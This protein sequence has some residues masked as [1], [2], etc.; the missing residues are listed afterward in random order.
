M[1]RTR[2]EIMKKIDFFL[3]ALKNLET[4]GTFTFSSDH[5]VRKI[6]EP[7]DFSQTDCVVE[8]GTGNGCITREL[9]DNMKP[10]AHL[11]SF[12][13]NDKFIDALDDLSDSRLKLIHDGAENFETYLDQMN[14][15][16]VDYI[17]SSLPMVILPKDLKSQIFNSIK[18]RLKPGGRFIQI[19]YSR[20][21][22]KEYR[23]AFKNVSYKH[24]FRNLPPAFIYVC[25]P[26]AA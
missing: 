15:D 19:S 16:Q 20:A 21:G 1:Q 11:L 24:T 23:A 25:D 3:T 14:I 10:D 4:V 5:L 12:E 13:I 18:K 22:L 17:V 7:I 9:L 8:L 6:V 26:V 2:S